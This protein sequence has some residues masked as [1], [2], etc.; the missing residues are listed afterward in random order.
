MRAARW[1]LVAVAVL[2]LAGCGQTH[3]HARTHVATLHLTA[4]DNHR[5][6]LLKRHEE[7]V[8]TLPSNRSGSWAGLRG[9][10]DTIWANGVGHRYVV[11]EQGVPGAAGKEIFRYRPVGKGHG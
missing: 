6:F 9:L 11:P 8:V 2:L 4:R 10:Q 5:V 1:S 7:V 3:A